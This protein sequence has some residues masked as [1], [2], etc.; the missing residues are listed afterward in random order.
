MCLFE[1][2]AYLNLVDAHSI[3]QQASLSVT[4]FHFLQEPGLQIINAMDRK[5]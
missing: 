5:E 3:L 4:G 1:R 2:P